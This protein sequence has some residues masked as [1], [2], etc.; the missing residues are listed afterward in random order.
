MNLLFDLLPRQE[1]VFWFTLDIFLMMYM[2]ISWIVRKAIA[3]D[4]WFNRNVLKWSEEKNFRWVF[5]GAQDNEV[6][7]YVKN[8]FSV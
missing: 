3:F 2:G 7:E 6:K 8:Q 4:M 5:A 1:V